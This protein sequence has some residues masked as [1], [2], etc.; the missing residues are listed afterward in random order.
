MVMSP[1]LCSNPRKR[2]L[3]IAVMIVA[4]MGSLVGVAIY[5]DRVAPFQRTVLVV[6]DTSVTMGYFLKRILNSDQAPIAMLQTLTHEAMMKQVAPQPPYNL[7]LTEVEIDQALRDMAR[8]ASAAITEPEFAE[9]Y[10]QQLNNSQFSDAEFR[11]IVRVHQLRQQLQDY[12]AKRVPPVPLET[13]LQAER[14]RHRVIYHGLDN[15]FDSATNAW[16]LEQLQKMG[17]TLGREP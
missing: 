6:N 15:G 14:Q 3:I 5:L 1:K 2:S 10:R 17:K 13:W 16:V 9:W 11:D 4:L 7:H 12:L 8:G